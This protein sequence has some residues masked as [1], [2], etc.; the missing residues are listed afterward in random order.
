MQSNGK[1][2][3]K[4]NKKYK[5][6]IISTLKNS[7]FNLMYRKRT[8]LVFGLDTKKP[9]LLYSRGFNTILVS[10]ILLQHIF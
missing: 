4:P 8:L 9:Q 10:V 1:K 6:L 3:P 7:G 5:H 2:V